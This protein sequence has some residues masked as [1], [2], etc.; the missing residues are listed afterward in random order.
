[1]LEETT[2]KSLFEQN[3]GTYHKQRTYSIPNPSLSERKESNVLGVI[4]S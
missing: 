4:S 1:M 2:M 3:G